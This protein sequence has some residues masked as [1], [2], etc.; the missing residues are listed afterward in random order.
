MTSSTGR[1]NRPAAKSAGVSFEA[2]ALTSL[3]DAACGYP[4]FLQTFGKATWDAAIDKQITAADAN[5]GLIK[6]RRSFDEGLYPSRWGQAT[7]TERRYLKAMAGLGADSA[8]TSDIVA[9]LGVAIGRLSTTRQQLLHKG[10]LS[11]SARGVVAFT[12]PGMLDYIE[13]QYGD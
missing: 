2:A 5:A 11:A 12:V 6:G 3:L 8:R 4:F 10:V 13:R 7:R 1:R 9:H